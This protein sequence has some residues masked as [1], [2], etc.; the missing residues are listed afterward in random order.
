MSSFNIYDFTK[1]YTVFTCTLVHYKTPKSITHLLYHSLSHE[2][3][4]HV[5]QGSGHISLGAIKSQ[6]IVS[7]ADHVGS[8]MLST[9]PMFV[10]LDLAHQRLVFNKVYHMRGGGKVSLANITF[11]QVNSYICYMKCLGFP[12]GARYR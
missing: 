4:A 6:S 3:L 2:K 9:Y 12:R 8:S 5:Y 7:E 11:S 10:W 1:F